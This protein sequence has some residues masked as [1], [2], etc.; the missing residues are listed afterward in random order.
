MI[1]TMF[2]ETLNPAQSC[3]GYAIIIPYRMIVKEE[4]Q[5]ELA[6]LSSPGKTYVFHL[7]L[8]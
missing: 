5:A 3:N 4:N 1:Y 2:S 7:L 6:E 8:F